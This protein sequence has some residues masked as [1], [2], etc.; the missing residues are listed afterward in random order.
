MI[1]IKFQWLF[2]F[3]SW[4]S[5]LEKLECMLFCVFE[6]NGYD[7]T[8]FYDNPKPHIKDMIEIYAYLVKLL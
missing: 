4:Q 6:I 8:I 3:K 1:I 7:M 2:V 5:Y